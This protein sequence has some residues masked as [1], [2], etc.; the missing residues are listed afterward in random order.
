MNA[1]AR[2][3]E[4]CLSTSGLACERGDR[5][6][7]AG[8]DL[9]LGAGEA[10]QVAGP[11]G[12]GKTTLLRVLCG[13]VWPSAGTVHWRGQ[14]IEAD[15]AALHADL[16]Y[17]GYAGGVKLELSPRENL[18][19][20]RALHRN[21]GAL[22]LDEALERVDLGGFEDVPAYTLSAGQ[23]RRISLAR[24]LSSAAPLWILD[25]PLTALDRDGTALVEAL[26]GEHLLAGGLLVFTT[27]QALASA[28]AGTRTLEL[29]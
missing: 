3:D 5:L 1:T 18:A 29:G 27:H 9:R 24:L 22:E 26:L 25:E 20:M 10:V 28:P 19:C 7:F 12:C 6:L 8:L 16:C 23:R 2:H 4:P 11:N 21:S 14:P 15:R 17:L 13:L